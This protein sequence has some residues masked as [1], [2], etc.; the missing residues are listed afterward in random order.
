MR[1]LADD[2]L[3]GREA[4]TRGYDLAALYAVAQF[5][6]LGLEPAG[7][8]GGYLQ[9]VPLVTG[10]R[11]LEGARFVYARDGKRVE[12]KPLADWMPAVNY[13][14]ESSE[15]TAPLVFVGQAVHAPELGHDDFA[16][17]DLK[18]KIAVY[19]GGAPARSRR[20][21]SPG[22]AR[23]TAAT[24]AARRGA[25]RRPPRRRTGRRPRTTPWPRAGCS[26]VPASTCGRRRT[27]PPPWI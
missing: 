9:R 25:R 15:V 20:A 27:E 10:T 3:E 18:G 26:G 5:R 21:R 13:N 11:V 19:F 23:R 1:F 7:D 14:A 12:L 6:L 16:G 17:V 4:G 2:L 22:A 8:D 24:C